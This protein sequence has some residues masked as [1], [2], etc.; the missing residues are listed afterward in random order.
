M[1][2]I[3]LSMQHIFP[4]KRSFVITRSTFAGSGHYAGHWLGDNQ[5]SWPPMKWSITGMLEF[6]LFGIPY[7]SDYYTHWT[8][9]SS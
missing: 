5:S 3:F 7:V 6:N 1:Y 9:H 8:F 4:D 2:K